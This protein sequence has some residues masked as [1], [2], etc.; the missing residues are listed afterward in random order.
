MDREIKELPFSPILSS[1]SIQGL[2]KLCFRQ[3]DSPIPSTDGIF[4]FGS[5]ISLDELSKKV[6][7]LIEK[8]VASRLILT[9]GIVAYHGCDTHS[10]PQSKMIHQMLQKFAPLEIEFLS[11]ETSQNTFENIRFGL[12]KIK[13]EIHSLCFIT[14]SFHCG[15][16]YLTL[17]KFLPQVVL[18]QSSYACLYPGEHQ[19]I[20][21]KNWFRFQNGKARVWGEFLRI[22]KYGQRG[23]ISTAEVSGLISEIEESVQEE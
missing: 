12:S 20:T 18:F 14:K 8:K 19:Q 5:T 21:A 3:D 4:I 16:S 6:H 1:R 17:R 13:T 2:T 23:D 7:E 10:I 9:G 22:R 11:E 15:R